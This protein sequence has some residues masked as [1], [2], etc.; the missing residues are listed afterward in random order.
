M[1]GDILPRKRQ[2]QLS[3]DY[4]VAVGFHDPAVW[5][6]GGKCCSATRHNQLVSGTISAL[7][8]CAH[9]ACLRTPLLPR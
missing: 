2:P 9:R 4:C 1:L 6:G 8:Q 7:G 5:V 3:P